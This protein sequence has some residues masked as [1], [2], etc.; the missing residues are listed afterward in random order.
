M[1]TGVAFIVCPIIAHMIYFT[2]IRQSNEL[3]IGAGTSRPIRI[4]KNM[5]LIASSC[6]SVVLI[7]LTGHWKNLAVSYAVSTLCTY[8]RAADF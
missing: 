6:I 2:S 8:E 5:V 4:T 7:V 1:F 3:V